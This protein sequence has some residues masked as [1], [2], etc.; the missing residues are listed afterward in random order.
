MPSGFPFGFLVVMGLGFEGKAPILPHA[1]E[2]R[3]R[4]R[5][6]STGLIGDEGGGLLLIGLWLDPEP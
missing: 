6:Q 5:V 2:L 3:L 4:E 1:A